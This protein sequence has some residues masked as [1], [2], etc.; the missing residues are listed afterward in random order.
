MIEDMPGESTDPAHKCEIEVTSFSWSE[1][2][3]TPVGVSVTPSKVAMNDLSVQMAVNKASPSL[4]LHCAKGQHVKSAILTIRKPG[5]GR[6]NYL[7]WKISDVLITSYGT[8]LN[9]GDPKPIDHI[10]LNFKR[11]EVEYIETLPTGKPGKPVKAGWDTVL[12]GPV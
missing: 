3:P 8:A 4:F 9:P 7:K 11:I 10:T 6:E 5:T 12:N 2:N 1:S